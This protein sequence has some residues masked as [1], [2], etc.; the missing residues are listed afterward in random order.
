MANTAA[1]PQSLNEFLAEQWRLIDAPEPVKAAGTM[2]IDYI[3]DRGYLTVGLSNYIIKTGLRLLS[4]IFKRPLTLYKGSNR[5]A[6]VQ[7][8]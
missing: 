7:G 5:P 3:D 4:S 1:G 8:I 2:I 6:S